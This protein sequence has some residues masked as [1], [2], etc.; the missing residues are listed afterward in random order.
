MLRV[1]V[2]LLVVCSLAGAAQ[3][4]QVSSGRVR[5]KGYLTKSGHYVAPHYRTHPDKNFY[6]NWSTKGNE[7]PYNQV[8][9][10]RKQKPLRRRPAKLFH[11]QRRPKGQ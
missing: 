8:K 10:K 2:V 7:D 9:G 6:N 4:R 11:K 3:K 1:L 5:V